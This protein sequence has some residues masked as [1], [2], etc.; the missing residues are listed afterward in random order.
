LKRQFEEQRLTCLA[1]PEFSRIA[2]SYAA[3][4][5]IAW[6]KIVGFDVSPVTDSSL[7]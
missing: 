4:F 6:W 7:I 2:T 1:V 5:L 3:L